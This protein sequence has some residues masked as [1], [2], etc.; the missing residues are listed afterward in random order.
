MKSLD[1]QELEV[2]LA[3]AETLL[4]REGGGTPKL[5][6]FHLKI[7]EMLQA[8]TAERLRAQQREHETNRPW[9]KT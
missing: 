3:K 5:K 1:L 2:A 4:A 9:G 6:E 8:V 7:R